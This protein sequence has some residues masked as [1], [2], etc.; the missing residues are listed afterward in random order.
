MTTRQRVSARSAPDARVDVAPSSSARPQR[1]SGARRA[2]SGAALRVGVERY[3][4]YAVAQRAVVFRHTQRL[5]AFIVRY[6]R[7]D[8]SEFE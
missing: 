5:C 1:V 2:R 8:P 4:P 3:A 7:I 6:G